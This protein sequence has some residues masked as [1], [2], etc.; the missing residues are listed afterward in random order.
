L[1][2]VLAVL[3]TQDTGENS[4]QPLYIGLSLCC[5]LVTTT[6]DSR[7][8]PLSQLLILQ[9]HRRQLYVFNTGLLPLS[10]ADS[11]TSISDSFDTTCV[12]VA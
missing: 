11:R 8:T 10:S 5:G 9:A 12:L 4:L 2:G 1:Y 6:K 3:A 7:G